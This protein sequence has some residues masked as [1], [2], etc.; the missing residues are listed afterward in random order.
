MRSVLV[1][2]TQKVIL[3]LPMTILLA[4]MAILPSAYA[5]SCTS[6]ADCNY[7]A[8]NAV[9][10]ICTASNGDCPVPCTSICLNKAGKSMA[11][12]NQCGTMGWSCSGFFVQTCPEPTCSAGS[13][14]S[15][16][17]SSTCALC[18]AGKYSNTTGASARDACEH[19]VARFVSLICSQRLKPLIEFDQIR[20]TLH[21]KKLRFKILGTQHTKFENNAKPKSE[22]SI[23]PSCQCESQSTD[24]D[25][26]SVAWR[27]A[28]RCLQRAARAR[29]ERTRLAQAPPP[30][31][32][33]APDP[34]PAR[35]VFPSLRL[36]LSYRRSLPH[37]LLL[38]TVHNRYL[39]LV[40][41][42]LSLTSLVAG[43][44]AT[45]PGG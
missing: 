13:Y 16:A 18:I 39:P 20:M 15:F 11:A 45:R 42:S 6:D 22:K 34:T 25:L 44:E 43:S 40:S 35:L 30:A 1:K 37:S 10:P 2:Q 14:S 27:Q 17:G 28:R 23:A 31:R 38:M 21:Q 12:T 24:L 41:L 26:A 8:C 4:M 7:T 36:G 19:A 9:S 29:T 33:A 5:F 32:A 3:V